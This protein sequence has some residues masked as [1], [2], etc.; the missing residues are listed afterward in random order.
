MFLYICIYLSDLYISHRHAYIC[1]YAYIQYIFTF[2]TFYTFT[3][4]YIYLHLTPFCI[5]CFFAC[6]LSFFFYLIFI[7]LFSIIL[8]MYCPLPAVTIK[9]SHSSD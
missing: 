9:I 8:I 5:N 7:C 3:Y 1:V 4:I 6:H 2:S